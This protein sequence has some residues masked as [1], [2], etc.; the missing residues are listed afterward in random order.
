MI[1]IMVLEDIKQI[2]Q[3]FTLWGSV[4]DAKKR[5][6]QQIAQFLNQQLDSIQYLSYPNNHGGYSHLPIKS[7]QV[8]SSISGNLVLVFLI[9][10]DRIPEDLTPGTILFK[11]EQ[12]NSS[13]SAKLSASSL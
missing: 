12:V 6:S 10:S 8:P 2:S 9:E 1:E 3:G 11:D 5:T 7:F 13:S 4:P